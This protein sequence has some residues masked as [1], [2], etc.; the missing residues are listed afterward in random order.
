MINLLPPEFKDEISFARYNT[1]LTRWIAGAMVG[2]VGVAMVVLGGQLY[3]KQNTESYKNA[4]TRSKERLVEQEQTESLARVKG[5][6]ESFK[7]VV[8]V[9]SRE[10]LFSKL[11]PQ[12]GA[13]MPQGTILGNLSLNTEDGQTAFDLTASAVDYHSASQIQVNLQDPSNKLFEKADLNSITCGQS[14]KEISEYP[15]RAQLRVLP[16]SQSQFLLINPETKQ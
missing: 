10:V 8:D 3:L 15:C 1:Q 11:L 13:I 12:V 7:L 16:S 5:I 2:L 14:E 4:V 9:L 6:Q